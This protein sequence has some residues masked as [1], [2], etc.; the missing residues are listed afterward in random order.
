MT[1]SSLLRARG[2]FEALEDL[3]AEDVDHVGWQD[4]PGAA[5]MVLAD[6]DFGKRGA[7]GLLGDDPHE[8]Q[9]DRI[10]VADIVEA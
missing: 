2:D 10:I 9:R 7:D 5:G 4:E 1:L 8:E 6:V 3:G